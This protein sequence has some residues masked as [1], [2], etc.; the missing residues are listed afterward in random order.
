MDGYSYD[1]AGNMT[2]DGTHGYTFD[3][4]N[5]I[6]KVDNGA[7]ATYVYDA[8][9]HRVQKTSTTGNNSDPAGTWILFYDQAGRWVQK[10]NSPG[11]T[12]VEGNI[13][14]GGRHLASVGGGTN[15]SHS[16]WLGTERLRTSYAGA[17]CESI[18]SLPFGDA[19]T[20]TGACYHPS[21]LHF[22][23]KERDAESGLDNFGARYDS[24]SLGRFMSPYPIGGRPAFPQSWN[25]YAYIANNP[26]NAVDPT[27]LDC[28]Y[29]NNTGKYEGFNSGD[30]DN[31]TEAKA[32]SGYYV[33][34]TVDTISTTTGDASGVVTGY[35]GT[36]EAGTLLSGT[37]STPLNSTPSDALNANAVAIFSDINQRNIIGN[38]F[39][40]YGAGA[41]TGA[42]LGAACYYLCPAA[43]VTTLGATVGGPAGPLVTD[44]DLQKIVSSLFQ[45]TDKLPGGTAG[46]VTYE[47]KMGD[48]LSQAGHA[49]K[50]A[51]TITA[52]TNLLKSGILS[53]NDQAAAR[54]MIQQLSDALAT[55]PFGQNP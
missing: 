39:K 35:S 21:P 24:S 14:A 41:V 6:I 26:L 1:S 53:V 17:T 8:D 22:T 36:G 49:E 32:N 42:T 27:G 46:A 10:F 23:G 54:Q 33:N 7:T 55:K 38:T 31:S 9:G 44:P 5:R 3:A 12:F 16:D 43:T 29:I 30:C 25:L 47:L 40:I 51:N 34:G 11:N 15:F 18:A 4:E 50:A 19:L 37:F 48:L 28:I 45:A 52:L 20:T 2:N 13:Y